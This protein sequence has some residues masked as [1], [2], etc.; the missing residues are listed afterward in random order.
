MLGVVLY[1]MS[2]KSLL[3]PAVLVSAISAIYA[4]RSDGLQHIPS[5]HWS[6]QWSR[7]HEL[8]TKYYSST[9]ISYYHAHMNLGG[10]NGFR[11]LV[12]VA[13]NEVR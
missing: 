5:I 1:A 8:Y 11:P 13:P 3:I 6:V 2:L 9:K 12:R 7:L 4:Y 10:K